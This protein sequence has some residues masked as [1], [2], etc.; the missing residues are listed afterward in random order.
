MMNV[1]YHFHGE[2]ILH[3]R[4]REEQ[5]YDYVTE[6]MELLHPRSSARPVSLLLG[7]S[8]YRKHIL[9][10]PICCCAD[11]LKRSELAEQSSC[12]RPLLSAIDVCHSSRCRAAFLAQLSLVWAL[13]DQSR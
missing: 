4:E 1:C 6:R 10:V 12:T 5:H 3:K 2:L 11:L 8:S 9:L 13:E 7:S